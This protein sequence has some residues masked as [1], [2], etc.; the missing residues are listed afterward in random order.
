MEVT[1]TKVAVSLARVSA[2]ITRF[3]QAKS[4]SPIEDDPWSKGVT[5]KGGGWATSDSDDIPPF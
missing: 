5:V 4:V 3:A 2:N 1:A